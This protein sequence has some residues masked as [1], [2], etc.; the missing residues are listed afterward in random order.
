MSDYRSLEANHAAFWHTANLVVNRIEAFQPELVIVC[1]SSGEMA[2]R[3]AER[4]WNATAT[5]ALPPVMRMHF[6]VDNPPL[7]PMEWE[8]HQLAV[9]EP[10]DE[11]RGQIA[12]WALDQPGWLSGVREA[13]LSRQGREP[14]RI[15]VVDDVVFG[16]Q[17]AAVAMGLVHAAFPESGVE[18]LHGFHVMW[19]FELMEHWLA[20]RADA[21]PA[22][23]R[24]RAF[25]DRKVAHN[26]ET[27][28]TTGLW[29]CSK[30]Y[31]RAP[32][33]STSLEPFD[34]AA[35][36]GEEPN[37]TVAD[38]QAIRQF[39]LQQ[40]DIAIDDRLEAQGFVRSEADRQGTGGVFRRGPVMCLWQELATK[41]CITVIDAV[42]ATGWDA[43]HV[44]EILDENVDQDEW[45]RREGDTY[46]IQNG[47][48]L[49]HPET[50][51]T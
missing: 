41:G 44:H 36:L 13:V 26:K 8:D 25:L 47:Y 31:V 1:L 3:A 40:I 37:L 24:I 45:L 21:G 42:V 4:L 34:I 49:G 2:W 19:R 12:H 5:A 32:M 38:I 33:A 16:G 30:F 35:R 18:L 51:T 46:A 28:T 43:A 14:A 39:Y 23:E 48:L 10:M 6:H 20:A 7:I 29:H 11:W 15:L 9:G 17:T 27:P 22:G 50:A